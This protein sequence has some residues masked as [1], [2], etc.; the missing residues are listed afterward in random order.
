MYTSQGSVHTTLTSTHLLV[1]LSQSKWVPPARSC[2]DVS[3]LNLIVEKFRD[4]C[5]VVQYLAPLTVDAYA[6]QQIECDLYLH[7][8]QMCNIDNITMRVEL[9]IL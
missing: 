1:D 7:N 9:T 6:V 3:L 8:L 5:I 4:V 2:T